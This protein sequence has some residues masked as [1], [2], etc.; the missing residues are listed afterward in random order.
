MVKPLSSAAGNPV[1]ALEE[2]SRLSGILI[3][4][5]CYG[6]RFT[7][8]VVDVYGSCLCMVIAL[9]SA[10]KYYCSVLLRKNGNSGEFYSFL[11]VDWVYHRFV[12]VKGVAYGKDYG[13]GFSGGTCS[14]VL[15]GKP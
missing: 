13:L 5:D 14:E 2:K 12:T 8:G 3:L 7:L 6:E 9:V 4:D 1:S 11:V 10:A 15:Q